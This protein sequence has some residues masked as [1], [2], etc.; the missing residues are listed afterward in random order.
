MASNFSF[1][2]INTKDKKKSLNQDLVDSPII[3]DRS[4]TPST[5][6]KA[7]VVV[8][9]ERFYKGKE[10]EAI[11]NWL[12]KN[13]LKK[14]IIMCPLKYD[15]T[16]DYVQDELHEGVTGYYIKNINQFRKY[17]PSLSP[18][19][20]A[21]QAIYS[22]LQED[23]VQFNHA[24]QRPFCVTNFWFS[25]DLTSNGN[26]VYLPHRRHRSGPQSRPQRPD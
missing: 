5:K 21:G 18:I 2:G 17:I 8:L 13:G 23:D 15:V 12:R 19:L 25:Y 16:P 4:D 20:V 1:G 22:L 9:V 3:V 6:F 24:D 11:E 10:I 26:Y 7:P 14:Y